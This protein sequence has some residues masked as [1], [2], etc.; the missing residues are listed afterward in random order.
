MSAVGHKNNLV[1]LF[2]QCPILDK[3]ID[4]NL[5]FISYSNP[6][7]SLKKYPRPGIV[8]VPS[9]V[10]HLI[11]IIILILYYYYFIYPQLVFP[12]LL[13]SHTLLEKLHWNNK[14]SMLSNSSA[15]NKL[16]ILRKVPSKCLIIKKHF[17]HFF[18]SSFFQECIT[19]FLKLFVVN[20]IVQNGK[21]LYFIFSF[22]IFC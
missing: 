20:F 4:Q 21:N 19:L 13:Q 11:F 16:S 18:F 6:V 14:Y 17:F 8:L 5:P 22:C 2:L 7:F 9:Y 1:T 10:W 15:Y 12:V 3:N